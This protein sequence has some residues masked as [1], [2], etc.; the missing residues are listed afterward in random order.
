MP[1]DPRL[2]AI[3]IKTGVV[4]RLSKE[5]LSYEKEA[6][7]L[8]AKLEVFKNSDAGADDANVARQNAVLQESKMMIPDSQKR[9]RIG[10]DEL[11][12]VVQEADEDIKQSEIFKTALQVLEDAKPHL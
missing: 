4:K 9:L 7:D 10:Y 6:T 12:T 8:E 3:R 5:K 2:R 11:V 1:E